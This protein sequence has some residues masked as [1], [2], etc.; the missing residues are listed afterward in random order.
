[1]CL[2]T[3]GST[4][5]GSLLPMRPRFRLLSIA[6]E[7][8]PAAAVC[9]AFAAVL[10]C[11]STP[12]FDEAAGLP[13][14]LLSELPACFLAASAVFGVLYDN[15]PLS[16]HAAAT[17]RETAAA[18]PVVT[19]F[20]KWLLQR[21]GVAQQQPAGFPAADSGNGMRTLRASHANFHND[22]AIQKRH[23]D[24]FHTCTCAA[25]VTSAQRYSYILG[26]LGIG[27][28][29]TC[30]AGCRNCVPASARRALSIYMA[31]NQRAR[32]DSENC[33]SI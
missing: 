2:W 9:T 14:R 11:R 21:F 23:G 12:V 31:H 6:A 16:A 20:G 13:S 26:A 17:A 5:G 15:I 22:S 7:P 32:L 1:M 3:A 28:F 30:T 10:A 24:T 19:A 33:I 29:H 27:C 18:R 25:P 8:M 4:T